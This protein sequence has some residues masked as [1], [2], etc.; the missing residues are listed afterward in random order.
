MRIKTLLAAAFFC[1]CLSPLVA[2]EPSG[3]G[4]PS[5]TTSV[6]TPTE[7]EME[8]T[9]EIIRTN[10]KYEQVFTT[11]LLAEIEKRRD[12]VKEVLYEVSPYVTIRIF[13]RSVINSR[14]SS[15]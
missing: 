7:Q 14:K 3:S 2:Q 1:F 8:G 6:T 4:D 10:N 13:P 5:K 15:K 12:D 9:Y 11:E